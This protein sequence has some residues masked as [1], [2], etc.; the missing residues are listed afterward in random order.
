V[1]K[2]V[3]FYEKGQ[4]KP[5][6]EKKNFNGKKK[7]H[8]QPEKGTLEGGTISFTKESEKKSTIKMDGTV[9]MREWLVGP[10][11]AEKTEWRRPRQ[12][13]KFLRKGKGR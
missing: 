13:T 7:S 10:L 12:K 1:T 9:P 2:G 6:R 11:P 4:R 8:L 5:R 3:A